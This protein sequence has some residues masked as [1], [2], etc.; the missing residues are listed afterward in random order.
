MGKRE[1]FPAVFD[2]HTHLFS[3][4]VIANV[5]SLN[6]LAAALCLNADGGARDRTNK[7][8]LKRESEAAGVQGCL[9]LPTAPV[10]GVRK[11]ND[12]FLKAVEGEGN[13]FTAGTLHPGYPG[14]DQ[15]MEWL[16]SRGVRALKLCSFSQG[17]DLESE[18][19][20]RLFERIRAHNVLGKPRFFVILDTFYQADI[21]FRAPKAH[22]TTPEKLSRLVAGFPEIDFVGA[23]MGGLRAPAREIK[24]H[25][26]PTQ[27]LYLDTS[28]A[29]H[30]L[31]SAEFVG[32]LQ[33]HGPEH[34]LF[35]T[36][37]PW[38]THG[39]EVGR[40]EDLLQR[41]GFSFQERSRI[42][43]GN[44]CRLLGLA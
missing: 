32:M 25:L 13:L 34:I 14:I 22:L 36:D 33:L 10:K 8:A 35:G 4:A 42:F 40:I 24:E 37:W 3:P 38:F 19:T 16:S 27:N 20:F 31:S 1:N 11:V 9:L 17:F 6:G 26:A 5:S 39:E 28:N 7:V 18:E 29:A 30:L 43:S 23:H 2:S 44:I 12:Q 15:E 21:Y 41:A